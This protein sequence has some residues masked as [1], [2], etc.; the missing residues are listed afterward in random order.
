MT[1]PG[2]AEF[3]YAKYDT[4]GD[5]APSYALTI[6]PHSVATWTREQKERI[7][8]LLKPSSTQSPDEET[9]ESRV[10]RLELATSIMKC[11]DCN[12]KCTRGLALVGW[13]N[14]FRH[15]CLEPS[16]HCNPCQTIELD[17]S[18]CAAA[19]S[20]VRCL[21]LDPKVA[22]IKD[23]DE[24]DARLLC[25]NCMPETSRGVT[26]LKVYTWRECVRTHSHLLTTSAGTYLYF[27]SSCI[28]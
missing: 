24:R 16:P 26:G 23:M 18:A 27:D 11:N 14:I 28:S 10:R 5:V 12:F 3:L 13:E 19:A 25:G 6:F 1:I 4:R 22:T 2:F 20:L 8:A 21:G 7:T 9:F 17:E 15:L